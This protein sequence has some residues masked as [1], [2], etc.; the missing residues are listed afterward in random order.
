MDSLLNILMDLPWGEL[1][2]GEEFFQSES[3]VFANEGNV[4]FSHALWICFF[5]FI[6]D[7]IFRPYP[8]SYSSRKLRAGKWFNDIIMDTRRHFSAQGGDLMDNPTYL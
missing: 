8:L 4:I 2:N 7:Y 1:S 6:V 5:D 3:S